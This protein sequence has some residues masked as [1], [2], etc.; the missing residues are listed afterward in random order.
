MKIISAQQ[1]II[2]VNTLW[3]SKDSCC[4]EHLNECDF[5]E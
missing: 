1:K 4:L 2:S 5:R 3:D